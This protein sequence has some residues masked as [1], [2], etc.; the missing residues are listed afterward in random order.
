MKRKVSQFI[1]L[2]IIV[3]IS[4]IS[5]LGISMNVTQLVESTPLTSCEGSQLQFNASKAYDHII[6]QLNFGFRVPG[7]Q[8]HDDCANWINQTLQNIT[9]AVI[10]QEFTIQKSGQPAYQCQNILGKLNT[11]ETDIIIL[12]AHWD[13]RAVAEKDSYNKTQPIPGAN[14]GASGVA[15]LL[16]L[17]RI[18][19]QSKAEINAQIW[20]VCLDAEDQG[21][22]GI[23]GWRWCEGAI[24]FNNALESF[25]NSDNESINCF[26]LL[27]MVGGTN[28]KFIDEA[29]STNTL[30]NAM[31]LEGRSLGY[32]EQF[33]E[34]PKLMA[35]TD[36]H[37][38]FLENNIASVDVIIDFIDGP[39][40]HH[41]KHSDDLS[42][43]D[44]NSLNITGRTTES[45]IKTYYNST[46]LPNWGNPSNNDMW[47]LWLWPVLIITVIGIAFVFIIKYSREK[48]FNKL[49][50]KRE[51]LMSFLSVFSLV[52]LYTLGSFSDD[53]SWRGGEGIYPL[54]S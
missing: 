21:N 31:F 33:P 29:H 27:D 11:N 3:Q 17:A 6:T 25:Y 28:L 53:L 48:S 34:W 54:R 22:Y 52:I 2:F 8:A 26:I 37:V 49:P 14:D 10:V 44:I 39:W 15:V 43:I 18:L 35:I 24:A 20:L 47:Q 12:G 13:S 38:P 50:V 30:Q 4:V 1:V 46:S 41:H 42:N 32:I 23:E 45:F 40:K 7:Y 19:N 36:D 16:E 5:G 9:E 51:R